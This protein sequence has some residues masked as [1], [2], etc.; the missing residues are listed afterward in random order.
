MNALRPYQHQTVQRALRAGGGVIEAPTGSGKTRMGLELARHHGLPVLVLVHTRELV[1]QWKSAGAELNAQLANLDAPMPRGLVVATVQSLSARLSRVRAWAQP[2]RAIL[3]DEAHHMGAATWQAVLKAL[4]GVPTYGL[5]ATPDRHDGNNKPLRTLVG[6]TVARVS[7][8]SAERTG[9][10]L[11]PLVRFYATH[12]SPDS[13]DS[14]DDLVVSDRR[15]KVITDLV[16]AQVRDRRRCLVIVDR[17]DHAD[18][19]VEGLAQR[20]GHRVRAASLHGQLGSERAKVLAG[21]RRGSLDVLVATS[22]VDEGLDLPDLD[23]LVLATPTAAQGRTQQR[24]GRILRPS[25]RKQAPVVW[26]LVDAHEPWRAAAE[27]RD[28][29]YTRRGW[30]VE[31]ITRHIQ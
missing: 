8:E 20:R 22:L 30:T 29:L 25:R 11:R 21:F 17:V 23:T 2:I 6:R 3:I 12:W 19:L 18:R 7:P 4:P 15:N 26:D 24:I 5:T 28:A 27:A 13:G 10:I 9:S 1:A 31:A 14:R 16:A